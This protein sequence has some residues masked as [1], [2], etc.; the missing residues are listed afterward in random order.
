MW[1]ATRALASATHTTAQGRRQVV[2][3]QLPV[4][5][6]LVFAD[7]NSGT[8]A[9]S[10]CW[11]GGGDVEQILDRVVLEQFIGHQKIRRWRGSSATAQHR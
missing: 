9:T 5:N 7:L 1:L 10:G 3:Q 11:P 6:L 2:A 8:S 4:Q